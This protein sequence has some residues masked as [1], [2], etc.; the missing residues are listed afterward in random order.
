M[1]IGNIL[2]PK[3]ICNSPPSQYCP[4]IIVKVRSGKAAGTIEDVSWDEMSSQQR[5]VL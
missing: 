5:G 3:L 4:S 2:Q 1:A